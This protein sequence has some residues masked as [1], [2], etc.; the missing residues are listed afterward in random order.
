M[1]R[2]SASQLQDWLPYADSITRFISTP[3]SLKYRG[4]FSSDIAPFTGSHNGQRRAGTPLTIGEACLKETCRLG[5]RRENGI[6]EQ[7]W[8]DGQVRP[9][10]GQESW[11]SWFPDGQGVYLCVTHE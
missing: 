8:C 5:R 3:A 11:R 7:S 4:I 2:F 10:V 9:D 1:Y 6:I